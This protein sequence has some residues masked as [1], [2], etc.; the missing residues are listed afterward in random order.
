MNSS[1]MYYKDRKKLIEIVEENCDMLLIQ[2]AMLE[3]SYIVENYALAKGIEF[4]KNNEYDAY[5]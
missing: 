2:E 3:L 5:F 1:P 4:L